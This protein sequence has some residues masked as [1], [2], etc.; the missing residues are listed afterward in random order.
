MLGILFFHLSLDVEHTHIGLLKLDDLAFKRTTDE[1]FMQYGRTQ[2]IESIIQ[3]RI[4]M[5]L[6]TQ[7]VH[8]NICL[9]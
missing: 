9:A 8:N 4:T 1:D 2:Q 5:V 6:L 3:Q 7:G